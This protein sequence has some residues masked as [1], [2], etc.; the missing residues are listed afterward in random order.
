[1]YSDDYL[2]IDLL[3]ERVKSG[4][5]EALW[6]LFDYY[7]PIILSCATQVCNNYRIIEKED[8]IS[9]CA[10]I[11]KYLC[12]KYDKN[13]SY[14]SYYISTRLQP[15]LISKVKS[16][17]LD[18][19]DIISLHSVPESEIQDTLFMIDSSL[20]DNTDLHFKIGDLP[21]NLKRAIEM[22]YFDGLTQVQCAAIL[23]ISQPA[24]SKRIKRALNILK[25]SY[26]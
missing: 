1:M 4:S 23:K 12:E 5:D 10:F 13:K 25:K 3:V 22:F 2:N 14:F 16:K 7:K 6:E 17:Y 8:L 24:F 21:D 9:E 20:E 26:A 18:K 15:Y 19:V 11:L